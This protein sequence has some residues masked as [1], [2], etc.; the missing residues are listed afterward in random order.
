MYAIVRQYEYQ[1]DRLADAEPVLAEIARLHA[2]Q[3]GY[4]GSLVIDDGRRLIAVNLWDSEQAAAVGRSAIGP[5]V[6]RLLEPLM[7]G[8][9]EPIAA[10]KVIASDTDERS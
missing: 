3:P 2:A 8:P 7:A 5:P 4:A 9:S 6:Q 1:P 10:G